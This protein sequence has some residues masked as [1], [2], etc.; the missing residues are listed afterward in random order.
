[1]TPADVALWARVSERT[2]RRAIAN[3]E[4]PAGRAGSQLRI[5]PEAARRWVFGG[6]DDA[7]VEPLR[8]AGDPV[9]LRG[10]HSDEGGSP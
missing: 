8:P 6:S 5:A 10:D 2:I 3:G 1:M 9:T 4:L 7:N